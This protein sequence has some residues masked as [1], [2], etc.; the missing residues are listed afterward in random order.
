[1][2]SGFFA[3][4]RRRCLGHLALGVALFSVLAGA[5]TMDD[6]HIR[7]AGAGFLLSSAHAGG[8][9]ENAPIFERQV[10]LTSIA[11]RHAANQVT[12]SMLLA[13]IVSALSVLNFAFL[14]HL[15]RVYASPRRMAWRRGRGL[16]S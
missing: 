7:S 14:R 12:A 8:A 10:M 16:R 4:R 15:R 6:G 1:M 11:E 3:R 5:L 2:R 13:A 9:V